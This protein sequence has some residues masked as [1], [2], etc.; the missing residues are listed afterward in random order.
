MLLLLLFK[1]CCWTASI[2]TVSTQR[3]N[4]FRDD[5]FDVSSTISPIPWS[6][7]RAGPQHLSYVGVQSFLVAHRVHAPSGVL[8][9]LGVVVEYLL[10]FGGRYHTL[11]DFAPPPQNREQRYYLPSDIKQH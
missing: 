6:L 5:Y 1:L 11:S 7:D 4:E 8:I 9:S 2:R 10:T 3:I